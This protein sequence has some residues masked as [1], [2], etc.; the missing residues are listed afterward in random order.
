LATAWKEYTGLPFVFAAWIANKKLPE[1]FIKA[2]NEAN[3]QGLQNI[4][5]V[6]AENPFSVYDLHKY[7]TQCIS[8][9]LTDNKR[10]GLDLFLGKLS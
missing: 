4:E 2:F 1:D 6:V 9:E 3:Q 5:T 7:Y 10:K 8:Y